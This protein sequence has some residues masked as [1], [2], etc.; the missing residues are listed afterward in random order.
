MSKYQPQHAPSKKP[1][2]LWHLV[3]L[4]VVVALLLVASPASAQSRPSSVTVHKG[5]TLSAIAVT[6][7][8][9]ASKYPSLAAGNGIKNPNHIEPGWVIKATCNL[10]P[11]SSAASRSAPRA[12]PSAAKWVTPLASYRLTSC[13]GDGRDHHG[14]DFDNVMGYPVRA[15][16]AGVVKQ[17]GW[18]GSG[19]GLEIMID[20]GGGVWTHYAHLSAVIV[21][22]GRVSAGT[23]IGRVGN[24]GAVSK[25]TGDGSHLHFEVETGNYGKRFIFGSQRNPAPFLRARGV[26]VGC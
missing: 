20:H 7:C 23:V 10:R 15:A 8:G 17:S 26:K 22:S 3:A 1:R 21:H 4:P 24:T 6:L 14:L 16:A 19:Y 13:W 2:K 11:G 5:D 25:R 12:T 9:S 18:I